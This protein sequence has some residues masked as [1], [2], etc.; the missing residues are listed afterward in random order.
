M[1]KW[2]R[3]N[4]SGF[5]DGALANPYRGILPRQ[6]SSTTGDLR[7]TCDRRFGI[8]IA[9]FTEEVTQTDAALGFGQLGAGQASNPFSHV[10]PFD[11]KSIET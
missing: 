5:T 3:Q 11:L 2:P 7:Q 8:D 9:V 6:P 1:R 4:G 10:R